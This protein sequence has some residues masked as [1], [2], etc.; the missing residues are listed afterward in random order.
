M[1][2][3][4]ESVPGSR[5]PDDPRRGHQ[6]RNRS[7]LPGTN[8][9]LEGEAE[10]TCDRQGRLGGVAHVCLRIHCPG[11]DVGSG[12]SV[13]NGL[14]IGPS[15]PEQAATDASQP[16]L[17]EAKR[18]FAQGAALYEEGDFEGARIEFE[19]AHELS[20]NHRILFNIAVVRLDL[21]DYVGAKRAFEQ[22]LAQGGD[23]LTADR[24]AEV[25]QEIEELAQRVGTLVITANV[26]GAT[27]VV[28]GRPVGE[29]PLTEEL[30]VSLGAHEVMVEA[31]GHERYLQT[32]DVGGG[33]RVGIDADLQRRATSA[34]PSPRPR[35]ADGPDRSPK[36]DRDAERR[37]RILKTLTWSFVGAT[38]A[39]GIGATVT[40]VLA[41][42]AD[43][44]LAN[45]RN[46]IPADRD[47]LDTLGT[48]T[49]RLALSTDI[50]LGVT[51]ALAIATIGLGIAAARSNRRSRSR[52]I[53]VLGDGLRLRF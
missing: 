22:Y 29:T 4:T 8:V 51:G 16:K 38:A 47:R 9:A 20:G 46:M 24:R 33:E 53:S 23:A 12:P 49:R 42:Q 37:P 35:L 17:E 43:D 28:D 40:G 3:R 26:A 7:D 36:T 18:R 48:K 45:E 21:H 44:E 30:S 31:D 25:Q 27:V 15:K 11:I 52:R 41:S 6:N 1:T 19:R 50:L 32:V 2:R 5:R 13:P 39:V 14:A 34:M 10:T